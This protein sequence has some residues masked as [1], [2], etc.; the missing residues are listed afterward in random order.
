VGGLQPGGNDVGETEDDVI[1]IRARAEGV[2]PTF[3]QKLNEHHTGGEPRQIN[4][5]RD[6]PEVFIS[7]V[8]RG[9]GEGASPNQGDE[10]EEG[11]PG[12]AC[13]LHR[14]GPREENRQGHLENT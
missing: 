5:G 3:M 12:S 14:K 7:E 10:V 11:Q 1:T 6:G 9:D 2:V 4:P 8:E 13:P